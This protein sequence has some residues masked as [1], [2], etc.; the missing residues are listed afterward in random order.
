MQATIHKSA[1]KHTSKNRTEDH[2]K[3]ITIRAA[4]QSPV[5]TPV[6]NYTGRSGLNKQKASSKEHQ[7]PTWVCLKIVYP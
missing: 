5:P 3:K 2:Q 7:I 6:P 4:Y 1:A